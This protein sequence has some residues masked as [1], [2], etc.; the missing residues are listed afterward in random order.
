MP[1][2]EILS[3]MSRPSRCGGD[4]EEAVLS[5]MRGKQWAQQRIAETRW[6]GGRK[7][8]T[9]R[10]RVAPYLD[11]MC[12]RTKDASGKC[13]RTRLILSRNDAIFCQA[14]GFTDATR[15]DKRDMMACGNF[16]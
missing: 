4:A 15:N 7:R 10:E 5:G 9:G 16:H 14:R 2:L 12:W 3:G 8:D 1:P 13:G 6:A 11:R